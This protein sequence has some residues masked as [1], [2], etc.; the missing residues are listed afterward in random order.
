MKLFNTLGREL[1]EFE[2]LEAKKARIY[3]CGPTVYDYQHIGNY[4]GYIYWD[5]LVRLL[6]SK[7]YEVKRVMNITDVGHLVSD[8]DEGEDKL[9][10][11]AQR[12]GKTARQVADFY[13]DDFLQSMKLLNLRE[14]DQYARAT[15]F[16]PQQIEIIQK[17]VEQGFAYQEEQA[18]YFDVAKLGDY[19]KLTGQDLSDKEVG[20][21][22]DVVTDSSKRSPQDFALWF[23]TVGRFADHEM[24]WPSPWGDG[25]P[26]WHIECSAIIH[27]ILGDPIDIH[28]GGVDHIGT[29]HTNEIAQ[30]EAAFGHPLAKYWLHNNHMMVDGQKISKSLGNGYTLADLRKRGFSPMDFKM[31]VLQSHYRSQSNFSWEAL[32]AAKNR[33][34]RIQNIAELRYQAVSRPDEAQATPIERSKADIIDSLENDLNTSEAISAVD[35]ELDNFEHFGLQKESMVNFVK[36]LENIDNLLGLEI[37]DSTPDISEAQK[38]IISEREEAR[39]KSDWSKS[40]EL[41]DKLT[42]QGIGIND[43]PHGQ[44]WYRL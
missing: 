20:A 11:G 21:R 8:S 43:T 33:L 31:L 15:D 10:K 5:V 2:P 9:E 36:W 38:E 19:G 35:S 1:E 42:E 27:A 24:H 14:P 18:I 41:R 7:G 23:F 40:D 26:G 25:F 44:I 22:S 28:T 16:I 34:K 13:T 3:T 39:K 6:G 30:T 37:V 29:H 17:L 32:E 4:S 12:E